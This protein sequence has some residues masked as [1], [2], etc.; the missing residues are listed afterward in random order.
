MPKHPT[1]KPH[2]SALRKRFRTLPGAHAARKAVAR[3][4]PIVL[5][6]K[7]AWAL[8][9]LLAI[10]VIVVISRRYVPVSHA[11]PVP[12]AQTR[13]GPLMG[14]AVSA[15]ER[16]NPLAGD[17]TLAYAEVTWRELEPEPGAYAFDEFEEEN[18]FS[19]LWQEGKRLILRFCVDRSDDGEPVDLPDW[20]YEQM[21]GA[22]KTYVSDLGVGFAPDIANPAFAEAHARVVQA[23][24]ARYDDHALV[25]AV[26]IGPLGYGLGY[27]PGLGKETPL[28]PDRRELGLRLWEY[29]QA[30]PRTQLLAGQP[31]AMAGEY[32]MGLYCDDFG[33]ARYCD[34][35]RAAVAVGDEGVLLDRLIAD[36]PYAWK[37]APVGGALRPE[38]IHGALAD[39][40]RLRGAL[41]SAHA[42]YARLPKGFAPTED[43]RNTLLQAASSMGYQLRV[44]KADWHSRVHDG[45]RLFV[46]VKW[47]N[48]G[49]APFM[50]QWPVA[51][52]L[53]SG[54]TLMCSTRADLDPRTLL[55]G[56]T[57]SSLPLDIPDGIAKGRY[58]LAI[59][60]LD[61]AT[62]EPGAQLSMEGRREDGWYKL[63]NVTVN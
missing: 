36:M 52:A 24:G 56:E 22:G 18:R 28:A 31:F 61:A 11:Y 30:F 58:T 13:P 27:V 2:E 10:V 25:A 46:N 42:T 53:F 43:E 54:D 38:S 59:A 48:D 14:W 34:A 33:N 29:S 32:G 41:S 55:P 23:L 5:H 45:F 44:D 26:E 57:Q 51:L 9:A 37:Q 19:E 4:T 20:L 12:L 50:Q 63:G 7:T 47:V 3:V 49:V 39:A 40:A 1:G 16:E 21:G 17:C 60:I 6:S 35:W 15:S 8:I 62:E